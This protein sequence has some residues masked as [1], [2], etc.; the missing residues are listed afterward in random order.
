LKY[1]IC[2]KEY[3]N[4]FVAG[5]RRSAERVSNTVAPRLVLY[6]GPGGQTRE[7]TPIEFRE[8]GFAAKGWGRYPDSASVRP[9]LG[10][11]GKYGRGCNGLFLESR[12]PRRDRE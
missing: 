7:M 1:S 6:L 9:D 8:G 10:A 5:G 3:Y 12:L 4:G 2:K 11:A